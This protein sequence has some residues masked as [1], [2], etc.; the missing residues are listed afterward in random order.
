MTKKH[1]GSR[2]AIGGLLAAGMLAG[3][4]FSAQAAGSSSTSAAGTSGVQSPDPS[5]RPVDSRAATPSTENGTLPAASPRAD[6]PAPP[7]VSD[8]GAEIM[9]EQNAMPAG[10]LITADG[11]RAYVSGSQ[12]AGIYVVNLKTRAVEKKIPVPGTGARHMAMNADRTRAVVTLDQDDT[13]MLGVAVLN[14]QTGE[15]ID[16]QIDPTSSASDIIMTADGASYYLLHSN[17]RITRVDTASGQVMAD[18]RL[19]PGNLTTGI[20]TPDQSRLITGRSTHPGLGGGGIYSVFDAQTLD[21]ILDTDQKTTWLY[22]GFD[23]DRDPNTLYLANSGVALKKLNPVTGDPT[24]SV[25]VGGRMTDVIGHDKEQ[26]AFGTAMEWKLVM[27]ADFAKGVRSESVRD[28]GAGATKLE[29]NPVTGELVTANRGSDSAP[30]SSITLITKPSVSDPANVTISA[31]GEEITF[32]SAVT[33]VKRGNGGGVIWQSSPD[34]ETW[35]DIEGAVGND[36][37]ITVTAENFNDS[38]RLRF[39]DDFWGIRG[40]SAPAKALADGPVITLEGALPDGTV[41][42]AYTPTIVTATGQ[43]DLT[44]SIGSDQTRAVAALP[45]G[46]E[47]NPT[48][49]EI[50][51]TPTTAGEYIVPIT[52]TDVFGTATRDFPLTVAAAA[53]PPT[54]VVPETPAPEVTTPVTPTVDGNLA[55][56]GAELTWPALAGA[57]ALL[58]AGAYALRRGRTA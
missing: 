9:L 26:R 25:G 45:E 2:I 34:G 29:E 47:L 40:E 11:A 20:L 58:L 4:A 14:L 48:T 57:L 38:Y 33:G 21:T 52:V 12:S 30:G 37:T 22:G 54:T 24:A 51:G 17:G 23:F 43:P 6:T 16:T 18:I 27:A 10:V 41:G 55:R 56:T 53:V 44:W 35:T 50:T 42:T 36:L 7:L 13:H 19:S 46:L 15:I 5:T 8:L 39:N 28:T 1:R 3:G 49:G 32:S 31:L